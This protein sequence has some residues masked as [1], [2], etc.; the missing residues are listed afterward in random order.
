MTLGCLNHG[1]VFRSCNHRRRFSVSLRSKIQKQP[2][3]LVTVTYLSSLNKLLKD[4]GGKNGLKHSGILG[5][6][7]P[8]G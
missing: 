7:G 5:I 4:I 3:I 6:M 8:F 2:I 1:L